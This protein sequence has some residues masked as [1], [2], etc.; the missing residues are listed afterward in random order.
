[1]VRMAWSV[2][3]QTKTKKKFPC[4]CIRSGTA[5]SVLATKSPHKRWV[6]WAKG[7]G[8]FFFP[9]PPSCLKRPKEKEKKRKGGK[10]K[11]CRQG[12]FIGF[13]YCSIGVY[14]APRA[15]PPLFPPHHIQ[16]GWL[17]SSILMADIHLLE[18]PAG[19]H[20]TMLFHG[21]LEFWFLPQTTTERERPGKALG[22]ALS[23]TGAPDCFLP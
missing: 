17:T 9:H 14:W 22:K 5:H 7:N 15:P 23:F 4:M 13:H 19:K 10:W 8:S 3:L 2:T 20:P 6:K 18:I 12:S 16:S 21:A 11:G 1:M